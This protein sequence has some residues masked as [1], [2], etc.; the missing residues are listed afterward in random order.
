MSA[1]RDNCRKTIKIL[2]ELTSLQ[3]SF[4]LLDNVIKTTTRRVNALKHVLVPY[5]EKTLLYITEELEEREKEDFYRLKKA[6][7]KRKFNKIPFILKATSLVSENFVTP[8]ILS[9]SIEKDILF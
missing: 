7:D 6:R 4:K 9:D 2:T 5:L 3:I 8:N 1:L